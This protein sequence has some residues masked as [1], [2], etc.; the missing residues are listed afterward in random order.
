MGRSV[1]LRERRVLRAVLRR[2]RAPIAGASTAA[3]GSSLSADDV[4]S[5]PFLPFEYVFLA[6]RMTF[7][8]P[9]PFLYSPLLFICFIVFFTCASHLFAIFN[10]TQ[11]IVLDYDIVDWRCFLHRLEGYRRVWKYWLFI[12]FRL[13]ST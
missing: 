1:Y 6:A 9:S 5:P 13:E 11:G 8:K 3:A 7:F 4:S 2:R 10:L 12:S